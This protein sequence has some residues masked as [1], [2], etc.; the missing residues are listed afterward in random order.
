[1]ALLWQDVRPGWVVSHLYSGSLH[2]VTSLSFRAD[3]G[4]HPFLI[5]RLHCLTDDCGGTDLYSP[6][7][8]ATTFRWQDQFDLQWDVLWH[9]ENTSDVESGTIDPR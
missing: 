7:R 6:M 1:M 2:V 3:D 4:S 5:V 8:P 9:P